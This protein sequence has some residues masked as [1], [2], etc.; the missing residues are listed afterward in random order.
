MTHIKQKIHQSLMR[1]IPHKK[2]RAGFVWLVSLLFMLII[3]IEAAVIGAVF[4]LESEKGQA[5]VK[6]QLDANLAPLGYEIDYSSFSYGLWH[7][8]AVN[9]VVIKQNDTV[10]M[11]LDRIVVRPEISKLALRHASVSVHAGQLDLLA[12]PQSEEQVA[13]NIPEEQPQDFVMPDIFITSFGVDNLTIDRLFIAA[14]IA[15][16]DMTLSP[17]LDAQVKI[18]GHFID[19]D[20]EL[21]VDRVDDLTPSWMPRNI[22]ASFG[23][24]AKIQAL[25]LHMSKIEGMAYEIAA[26]GALKGEDLAFDIEASVD[27]LVPW[28]GIEGEINAQAQ[29]SGV[30]TNPLIKAQGVVESPLLSDIGL[31]AVQVFVRDLTTTPDLRMQA[32]I[33][34]HYQQQEI[35]IASDIVMENNEL[36]LSNISGTAPEAV[37][38]GN[39]IVDIETALARGDIALNIDDISP[40]GDMVGVA[41]GGQAIIETSLLVSE[42]GQQAGSLSLQGNNLEYDGMTL[43]AIEAKTML[44]DIVNNPVPNSLDI[45]AKGLYVPNAVTVP[46]ADITIKARD[47]NIHDVSINAGVDMSGAGDVYTLNGS[48]AVKNILDKAGMPVIDN[49]D[50]HVKKAGSVLSLKGFIHHENLDITAQTQR[51][52]LRDIPYMPATLGDM[53]A[54]LVGGV[55]LKGALDAPIIELDI[56]TNKM[57]VLGQKTLLL[58]VSGGVQEGRGAVGLTVQGT[59]IETL[60]ARGNMPLELSLYPFATSLDAQTPLAGNLI[61]N[62]RID[63]MAVLFLPPLHEAKADVSADIAIAGVVSQPALEGFIRLRNGAYK[64]TSLGVDIREITATMAVDDMMVDITSMNARDDKDG[65][66][67]GSGDIDL[68]DIYASDVDVTLTNFHLFNG[69]MIDGVISADLNLGAYDDG[70]GVRGDIDI[71]P[72]NV[73]IPERFQTSIPTLNVVEKQDGGGAGIMAVPVYLDIDIVADNQIFVRGWGLDAEFGGDLDIQGTVDTPEIFGVLSSQRGRYEEFG[74]RFTIDRANIRFQGPMPPSPY[75]DIKATTQA[76]DIEA[77]IVLTGSV[78]E[79]EINLSSVPALPEDEVMSHIL[80]G[81]DMSNITPFQ[82]I[83]LKQSFD[84]F[85]GRGG[86]GFDPLGKLRNLTGL[87]DIRVDGDSGEDASV[88]VGKYLT[89]DVYLEL[90]QGQAEGSGAVRVEIELTPNI[91]VESEAGQ[92]AHSGGGIFWK[93]DY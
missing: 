70:F 73:M 60:S 15:G 31:S 33:A 74:K 4:W 7:G 53:D 51:F 42:K 82:A 88:G 81:E 9:D 21:D 25:D 2:M 34:S 22:Q 59:A 58:E 83:Q 37:M 10:L 69:D 3:L 13:E 92:D 89:D 41:V 79:P 61:L 24:D 23:Y 38:I 93:W 84:R 66:L 28:A 18:K 14:A 20:V 77:F 27:D 46:T 35:T 91:T 63:D 86:G 16:A 52:N 29:V 30:I 64:E 11:T 54:Y 26:E 19:G 45:K 39:I 67:R 76:D 49:L 12:L 43:S 57:T 90:E 8:L 56:S 32:E 50:I 75:L 40:Y 36:R 65:Q 47:A 78:N 72:T 62:G 85:S 68:S 17:S 48:A 87:D 80:F 5:F 71:G 1:L 44:D 6:T 55:T